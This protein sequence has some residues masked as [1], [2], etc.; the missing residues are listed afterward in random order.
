VVRINVY[1]FEDDNMGT[2]EK[3]LDG[4]FD[5]DKAEFVEEA[6]R[7]NGNNMV[8]V[9]TRD[10]FAHEGLYRTAKGRWVLHRWS[11]WQGT[12]PSY[13]FIPDDAAKTWLLTNEDDA[14]V[15]KWFGAIEEERGPGRPEIG[16]AVNIRFPKDLLT[17]IDDEA[18]ERGMKRAALVREL[19][20]R[21]LPA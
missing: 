21:G 5:A 6:T 17:R 18:A 16:E 8:S 7:W 4:W 20:D 15:E 14:L 11:Q 1:R 12:T 19:C 13:E 9:H 3:I 10:Q 2:V